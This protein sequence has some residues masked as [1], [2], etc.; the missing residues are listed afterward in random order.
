MKLPIQYNSELYS[1]AEKAEY[2]KLNA[3]ITPELISVA[4]KSKHILI[5]GHTKSGKVIIGRKIAEAL[6]CDLII[7]DDYKRLGW[8]KSMYFIKDKLLLDKYKDKQVVFEG[9]QTC[10]TLRKGVLRDDYYPDLVIHIKCN[11]SS[12]ASCYIYEGEGYKLKGDKVKNFN[13]KMLDK[14][15]YEWWLRL[16]EEKKP[17]ILEMDTSFK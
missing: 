1:Q 17:I 16:P 7:S 11:Y 3:L 6:G 8:S 14:I 12:I 15:F 9:V 10:R 13:S 5:Y 2:G 4:K